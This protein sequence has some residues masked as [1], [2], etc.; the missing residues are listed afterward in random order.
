MVAWEMR[1]L[2]QLKDWGSPELFTGGSA[3]KS[4]E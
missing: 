1:S 3:A 4:D 2:K